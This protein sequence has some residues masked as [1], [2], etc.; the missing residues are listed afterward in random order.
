MDRLNTIISKVEEL[1]K[2]MTP[3]QLSLYDD[4]YLYVLVENYLND[5]KSGKPSPDI[6]DSMLF[7][8]LN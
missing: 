4:N 8:L 5:F 6:K 3:E 2:K 1:K 7:I